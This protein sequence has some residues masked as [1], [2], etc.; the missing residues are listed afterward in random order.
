MAEVVWLREAIDQLD[1]IAAYVRQFDPAA[2]DR[3]AT[4]LVDTAT[5]LADFPNRGRPATNGT[6]EMVT[7][8]PYTLHY[9]V[10]DDLV[11]ILGVR[12]SA[13]SRSEG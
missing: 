10:R 12:H 1:L 6:R 9:E 3:I 11:T 13:R 7:V 4:S 2:A 5:S 8:P